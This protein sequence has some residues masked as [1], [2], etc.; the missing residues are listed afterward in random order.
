MLNRFRTIKNSWLFRLFAFV[1]LSGPLAALAQQGLSVQG[2]V[3]DANAPLAGVTVRAKDK[4]T[5]VSTGTDGQFTLQNIN[6]GD[7]L[8]FRIVGYI[9]SGNSREGYVI[10]Q[11]T[12]R[13]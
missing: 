1:C 6:I 12:A 3:T 8:I 2:Q 11:C 7:T 9:N 5:A 13:R 10:P 4:P